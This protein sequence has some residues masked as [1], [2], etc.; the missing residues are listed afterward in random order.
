MGSSFPNGLIT[1]ARAEVTL[2]P[3]AVVPTSTIRHVAISGVSVLARD[4]SGAGGPGCADH[5]FALFRCKDSKNT[6]FLEIQRV[7]CPTLVID[8]RCKGLARNLDTVSVQHISIRRVVTVQVK[9]GTAIEVCGNVR[10]IW[11]IHDK[12]P[13]IKV[14]IYFNPRISIWSVGP[15]P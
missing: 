3:G 15:I 6:L 11:I 10:E 4:L 12:L 14:V 2:C 8:G 7:Y 13:C 9:R 1:G 5:I